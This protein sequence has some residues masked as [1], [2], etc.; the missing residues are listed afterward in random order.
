[1]NVS[2]DTFLGEEFCSVRYNFVL[3][4]FDDVH[5]IT[6]FFQLSSYSFMIQKKIFQMKKQTFCT[7]KVSWEQSRHC[8]IDMGKVN[9]RYQFC[10][11]YVEYFRIKSGLIL[12]LSTISIFI[13]SRLLGYQKLMIYRFHI[14]QT[15]FRSR[16]NIIN[17]DD[18][19]S[20]VELLH[21]NRKEKI[22]SLIQNLNSKISYSRRDNF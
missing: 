11:Y 10:I 2:I 22:P 21:Q 6:I 17:T 7:P 3:N 12:F 13:I 4:V 19:I 14:F 9:K 5:L 15:Y 20:C 1:M 8:R 16:N 18:D